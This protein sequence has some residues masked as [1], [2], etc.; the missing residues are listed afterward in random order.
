MLALHR[1]VAT[2]SHYCAEA[3]PFRDCVVCCSRITRW[4]S[5]ELSAWRAGYETDYADNVRN[6]PLPF[7]TLKSHH[8][9]AVLSVRVQESA[10]PPVYITPLRPTSPNDRAS[11]RCH[12]IQF[13]HSYLRFLPGR[14]LKS[15][16]STK[17]A[18][19]F[20]GIKSR[21]SLLCAAVPCMPI[22]CMGLQHDLWNCVAYQA[23]T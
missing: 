5:S 1:C 9:K 22:H 15:S 3:H 19:D 21:T 17:T 18:L 14:A 10:P 23:R 2:F 4:R 13:N 20:L 8:R 6:V 12:G 7:D 16:V 11:S